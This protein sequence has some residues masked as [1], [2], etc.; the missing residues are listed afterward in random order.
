PSPPAEPAPAPEPEPEPQRE[1]EPAP[2][3]VELFPGAPRE[4][5]LW[6]LERLARDRAGQD[7]V[8]DE[9]R[10]YLLMYLREFA[11]PDGLLPPDFDALVRE[12]F[13]DLLT[14]GR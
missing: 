13:G 12:S 10:S 8:A 7:P 4:W 5:N 11:S 1:P 3:V 9:E 2:Q 14:A 6:E